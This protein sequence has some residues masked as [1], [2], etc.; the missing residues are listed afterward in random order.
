MLI[1][2]PL[3]AWLDVDRNTTSK[4]SRWEDELFCQVSGDLEDDNTVSVILQFKKQPGDTGFFSCEGIAATVL[5]TAVPISYQFVDSDK[6]W[7]KRPFVPPLA[8]TTT[9]PPVHMVKL[10]T[11]KGA[12]DGSL[13]QEEKTMAAAWL[14][15]NDDSNFMIA[16][17]VLHNVSSLSSYRDELEG[18]LYLLKHIE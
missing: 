11:D 10:L 6:V 16:S 5:P 3:G 8:P 17:V 12:S 4:Y 15:A 7:T 14:I 1:S 2:N 13:Y 18:T 9:S